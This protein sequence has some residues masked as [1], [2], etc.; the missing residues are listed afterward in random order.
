MRKRWNTKRIYGLD[1]SEVLLHRKN[2]KKYGK[3]LKFLALFYD[4]I[5]SLLSAKVEIKYPKGCQKT[6]FSHFLQSYNK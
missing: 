1:G 5:L 6:S 4:Q 3:R 2:L